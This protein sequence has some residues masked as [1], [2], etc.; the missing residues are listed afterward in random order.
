M[1]LSVI[2]DKTIN[3]LGN[4]SDFVSDMH[5]PILSFVNTSG[6]PSDISISLI[7]TTT[8][9]I[10]NFNSVNVS[11]IDYRFIN[12]TKHYTISIINASNP[13]HVVPYKIYINF[14]SLAVPPD[15]LSIIIA[16]LSNQITIQNNTITNL[17]IHCINYSQNLSVANSTISA[18]QQWNATNNAIITVLK[19]YGIDNVILTNRVSNL[20]N[21][22]ENL[23]SDKISAWTLI[24]DLNGTIV[25]LNDDVATQ[26]KIQNQLK[27]IFCLGYNDEK[28]DW[29]LYLNIAWLLIGGLI[30]GGLSV[31][32]S[33]SGGIVATGKN[34]AHFGGKLTSF[35]RGIKPTREESRIIDYGNMRPEVEEKFLIHKEELPVDNTE[36]PPITP[37]GKDFWKT[38]KGETLKDDIK[39]LK[40]D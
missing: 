11:P 2:G 29:H 30:F 12:N 34:I 27:D 39:K 13:L 14:S 22:N 17:T 38:P 19:Q 4:G 31:F 18:L 3:Y 25:G 37:E 9:T 8:G 6:L 24:R 23:T 7:E 35:G 32:V 40:N 28:N 20:S 33:R 36:K 26:K 5:T 10:I 16:N 1:P 21:E 15:P